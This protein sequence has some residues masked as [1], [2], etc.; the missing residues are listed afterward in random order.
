MTGAGAGVG[1]G[2]LAGAGSDVCVLDGLTSHA[3]SSNPLFELDEAAAGSFPEAAAGDD[4]LAS[5]D[6]ESFEKALRSTTLFVSTGGAG[7]PFLV[8]FRNVPPGPEKSPPSPS[9]PPFLFL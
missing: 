1:S 8:L 5:L 2:A 6:P 7:R 3:S 4:G 9:S